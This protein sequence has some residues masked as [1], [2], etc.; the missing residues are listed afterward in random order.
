MK[1]GQNDTNKVWLEQ[2]QSCGVTMRTTQDVANY[3]E[4]T[5]KIGYGVVPK[6]GD[7]I[8]NSCGVSNI[9]GGIYLKVR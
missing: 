7:V 9:G 3:M 5:K 8:K 4:E 1:D 2:M 6:V